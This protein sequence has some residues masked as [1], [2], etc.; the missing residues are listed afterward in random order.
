M[1][2]YQFELIITVERVMT[3]PPQR[4]HRFIAQARVDEDTVTA[5]GTTPDVAVRRL[6]V[7]IYG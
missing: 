4:G 7:K 1:A 5:K 6:L 3:D 2:G